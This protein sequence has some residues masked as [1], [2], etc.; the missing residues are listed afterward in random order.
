MPSSPKRMQ[1][2]KSNCGEAFP[3]LNLCTQSTCRVVGPKT[4]LHKMNHSSFLRFKEL[5]SFECRHSTQTILLN[6]FAEKA[7]R[8][9]VHNKA[10]NILAREKL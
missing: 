10:I 4:L 1:E 8:Q 3:P 7:G 6:S 9:S 5:I 2:F